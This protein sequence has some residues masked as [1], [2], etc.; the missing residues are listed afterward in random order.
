[1]RLLAG[2]RLASASA[3]WVPSFQVARAQ[4]VSQQD[5]ALGDGVGEAVFAVRHIVFVESRD[6]AFRMQQVVNEHR[7]ALDTEWRTAL[8]ELMAEVIV[9]SVV[10]LGDDV[11]SMHQACIV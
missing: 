9:R 3:P 10:E 1:M 4:S 5:I 2:R 7:T 11:R 8:A 6:E